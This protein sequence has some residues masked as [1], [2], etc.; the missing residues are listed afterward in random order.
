MPAH[1]VLDALALARKERQ[2]GSLLK[3]SRRRS[4]KH[5]RK[6][7][8]RNRETGIERRGGEEEAGDEETGTGTGTDDR[9]ESGGLQSCQLERRCNMGVRSSKCSLPLGRSSCDAPCAYHDD[10]SR[11]AAAWLESARSVAECPSHDPRQHLSP[12]SLV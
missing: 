9:G 1:R 5:G 10:P 7:Q 11:K 2:A 8:G 6:T 3:R 12:R 4:H